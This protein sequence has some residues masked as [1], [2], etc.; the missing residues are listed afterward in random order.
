MSKT[1]DSRLSEDPSD[2]FRRLISQAEEEV[3]N[4]PEDLP[5]QDDSDKSGEGHSDSEDKVANENG[6]LDQQPMNREMPDGSADGDLPDVVMDQGQSMDQDLGTIL[7]SELLA[8]KINAQRAQSIK[9][10]KV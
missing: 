7:L 10:F 9:V 1:D 3:E 5:L 4:L 6:E 2:R 8:K